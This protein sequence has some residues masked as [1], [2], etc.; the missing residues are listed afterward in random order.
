[1]KNGAA[2]KAIEQDN[3]TDLIK[4]ITPEDLAV[5]HSSQDGIFLSP[6]G[7]A[8]YLH[9]PE[10]FEWILKR[11]AGTESCTT[12]LKHM[13]FP[14]ASTPYRVTYSIVEHG[15][16]QEM[17]SAC[18]EKNETCERVKYYFNVRTQRRAKQR[19]FL[20]AVLSVHSN[21]RDLARLFDAHLI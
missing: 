12:A 9:S 15:Q 3:L 7:C 10:C 17:I 4:Y 13:I 18:I 20:A 11:V 16:C 21:N 19:A 5:E 8:W 2:Y 1:M 14:Y 6:L